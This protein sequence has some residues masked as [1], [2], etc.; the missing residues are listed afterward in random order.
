M[1]TT[2]K[3]QISRKEREIFLNGIVES[4]WPKL[5]E[6]KPRLRESDAPR[7]TTGWIR[8]SETAAYCYNVLS[9]TIYYNESENNLIEQIDSAIVVRDQIN[10]LVQHPKVE[11]LGFNFHIPS[12]ALMRVKRHLYHET[13]HAATFSSY[14]ISDISDMK[15][16]LMVEEA[17][18]EF[19]S[20]LLLRRD[21]AQNQTR[22]FLFD[23]I[24]YMSAHFHPELRP[25][26][27]GVMAAASYAERSTEDYEKFFAYLLKRKKPNSRVFDLLKELASNAFIH[28]KVN[29]T[30]TSYPSLLDMCNKSE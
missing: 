17:L 5:C 27:V 20:Y 9:N 21:L 2:E 7:V 16:S 23:H 28:N 24:R 14:S 3:K 11:Q 26:L 6:L 25:Y 4:A 18:A 30:D 15:N 10:E 12:Y 19:G 8:N 22:T 1:P 29:F 13:I